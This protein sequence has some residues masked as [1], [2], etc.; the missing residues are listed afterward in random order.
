MA[1]SVGPVADEVEQE[2]AEHSLGGQRHRSDERPD[3][4][5]GYPHEA[6]DRRQADHYHRADAEQGAGEQVPDV[7]AHLGAAELLA[8]PGEELLERYDE[9]EENGEDADRADVYDQTGRH[10]CSGAQS[11]P[12][13]GESLPARQWRRLECS[14]LGKIGF[15]RW[16]VSRGLHVTHRDRRGYGPESGMPL[17]R[18]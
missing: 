7:Q 12:P 13:L 18:P 9:H 1:E 4:E 14:C 6:E 5:A 10:D 16:V 11:E 2:E 15:R 8:V 3:G 17:I